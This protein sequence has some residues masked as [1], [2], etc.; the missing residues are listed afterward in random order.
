M[1]YLPLVD[2]LDCSE[3]HANY[4]IIANL[5]FKIIFFNTDVSLFN[6]LHALIIDRA[7]IC[8]K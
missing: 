4:I 5:N 6:F 3:F 8:A 2:T 1:Y 7:I